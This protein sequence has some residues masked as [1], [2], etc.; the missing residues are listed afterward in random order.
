[1]VS[2]ESMTMEESTSNVA[3]VVVSRMYFLAG[4][5]FEGF[6]S[7]LAVDQDTPSS[8]PYVSL[9]YDSLLYQTVQAEKER[10]QLV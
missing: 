4:V 7:L 8:L 2:T 6:S 1:M 3:D 10:V 5:V 9:L